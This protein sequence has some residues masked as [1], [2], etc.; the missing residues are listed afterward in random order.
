MED[1]GYIEGSYISSDIQVSSEEG[2]S[3]GK[4]KKKKRSAQFSFSPHGPNPKKDVVI[5][6][7]TEIWPGSDDMC[8]L[9]R[10][11]VRRDEKT[12]FNNEIIYLAYL[13]ISKFHILKYWVQSKLKWSN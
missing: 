12:K 8:A 13:A 11:I 2:L 1:Y 4:K 5:R 3:S 7:K 6:H 9:P 10:N